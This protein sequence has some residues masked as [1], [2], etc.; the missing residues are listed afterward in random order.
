MP[1]KLEFW[2]SFWLWICDTADNFL[3]QCY[4]TPKVIFKSFSSHFKSRAKKLFKSWPLSNTVTWY[5]LNT[6]TT[7]EIKNFRP[8]CLEKAVQIVPQ[9]Q[10][11]RRTRNIYPNQL[12]RKSKMST[13]ACLAQTHTVVTMPPMRLDK[14]TSLLNNSRCREYDGLPWGF[15]GQP[16][17]THTHSHRCGFS[18]VQ[19]MGLLK[20]EGSQTHMGLG[21]GLL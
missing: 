10:T 15:P 11:C 3:K 19:V 2:Y 7:K 6:E 21:Y 9:L 1:Q 13:Q 16:V 12:M 20:P 4:L 8:E 18:R 17:E 5:V 14:M